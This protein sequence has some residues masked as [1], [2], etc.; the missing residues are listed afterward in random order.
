MAN[1]ERPETPDDGG[2][3]TVLE[4]QPKTKKPKLYRVLFHNDDYTTMEFVEWVLQVV[5]HKS[6]AESR[7]LMLA[8]HHKGFGV[9]GVFTRDV[10]ES[11]AQQALDLA[12]EHGMPLQVTTEPD[13]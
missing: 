11:K 7:H 4:R 6:D 2:R 3:Q 1:P 12:D 5:F 13:E 9:A 8:I 10:A